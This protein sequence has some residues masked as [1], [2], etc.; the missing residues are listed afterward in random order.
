MLWECDKAEEA[1]VRIHARMTTC[2]PDCR[3][4][5]TSRDGFRTKGTSRQLSTIKSEERKKRRERKSRG[6]LKGGSLE[7]RHAPHRYTCIMPCRKFQRTFV[8]AREFFS[9]WSFREVISIF[10]AIPDITTWLYI[11]WNRDSTSIFVKE[12]NKKNTVII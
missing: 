4:K 10:L 5:D 8:L 9:F 12:I 7:I 3:I 6:R 1:C 11:D 2:V